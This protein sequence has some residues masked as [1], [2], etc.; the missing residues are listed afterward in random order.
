MLRF[1]VNKTNNQGRTTEILIDIPLHKT[2]LS[3]PFNSKKQ[4]PQKGQSCWYYV[5]NELRPRY[6]TGFDRN[7]PR[8]RD[9]K[10]FS[11]FRK[12]TYEIDEL[13]NTGKVI[14][15]RLRQENVEKP[16]KYFIENYSKNRIRSAQ[17]FGQNF[18]DPDELNLYRSFLSQN[19]HQ[20]FHTFIETTWAETRIKI[21]QATL[22]ALGKNPTFEIKNYLSKYIPETNPDTC[23]KEML[24]IHYHYLIQ[25]TA[26]ERY[27]L[28]ESSW[29]FKDGI[30]GLMDTLKKNG[31]CFIAGFFGIHFY[32]HPPKY[33]RT[34]FGKWRVHAWEPDQA[35]DTPEN[36]GVEHVILII[37]AKK[38]GNKED[39]YYLDPNDAKED[40]KIYRIPFEH[41]SSKLADVHGRHTREHGV[42]MPCEKPFAF[43]A[44]IAKMDY[45]NEFHQFFHNYLKT[46]TVDAIEEEFRQLKVKIP[47]INK[48][49]ESTQ[50]EARSKRCEM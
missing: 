35:V 34:S 2:Y 12:H 28:K 26:A 21:S 43:H 14:L 17:L 25:N 50:V 15:E 32:T 10:I 30:E 29:H 8:R 13:R 37:G 48:E 1:E 19:V 6:G 5:M 41:L 4:S 7:H 47:V 31:A 3:A 44:D 49:E 39:V 9:E 46:D 22:M 23:T 38:E 33:Q 27:E 36:V 18:L 45:L 11:S 20:Y 16:G 42:T 40:G 24:C